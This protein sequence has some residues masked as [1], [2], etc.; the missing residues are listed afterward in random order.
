ML[1]IECPDC[2][3]WVSLPF[4]IEIKETTCPKCAKAIPVRDVYVSAGPYTIHRDVLIKNMHRYKKL[5]TEAEKEFEAF[6]GVSAGRKNV[7]ITAK[8]VTMFINHLKEMLSGCRGS[9]RHT[10]EGDIT[11]KISINN[12]TFQGRVLNMSVSGLCLD[13]SASPALDLTDE[14]GITLSCAGK[15]LAVSGRVAWSNKQG[16]LGVKFTNLTAKAREAIEACI[17][18]KSVIIKTRK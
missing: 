8:S 15:E 5:L 11:A 9:T 3:E 12:M 4:D 13:A 1:K 17:T 18:E 16:V 6:E 7:D 10:L 2:S 14:L